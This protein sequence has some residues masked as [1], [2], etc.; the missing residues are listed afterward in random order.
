[1]HQQLRSVGR[2][3]LLLA[4]FLLTQTS[5]AQVS[6]T[7]GS[8]TY[9]Q[10]FNTLANT[11]TA[12]TWTNNT[13]LPGWLSTQTTYRAGT[14]SDNAGA[15]YSFGSAGATERA[16]GSVASSGASP[17][18]G[19][20]FTNSTGTPI[21][22]FQVNY[23]GEQW[24]NG[25]NTSAQKLTF[26]YVTGTISITAAGT[27]VATLDFTSPTTSPASNTAAVTLDGNLPAN[28]AKLSSTVTL[29]TPLADGQQILV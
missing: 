13:T 11:G 2:L 21:S 25:G 3:W 4:T 6:F 9:T 1:M 14:G 24:R 10:D 19:V 22:S 12:N 29:S 8:L 16:L 27:N 5:W 18:Y 23:T 28:Q 20:V 15:L 26:S 17:Q 7:P